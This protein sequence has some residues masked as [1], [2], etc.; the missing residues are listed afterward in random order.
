MNKNLLTFAETPRE[1]LEALA[2]LLDAGEPI[3]HQISE[4]CATLIREALGNDCRMA[5]NKRGRPSAEAV[6]RERADAVAMLHIIDG[7]KVNDAIAQVAAEYRR[8]F[9]TVQKDYKKW[10]R[11]A[12]WMARSLKE[13]KGGRW[14][15][16][17]KS[18]QENLRTFRDENGGYLDKATADEVAG[19][20]P[21]R[22]VVDLNERIV[23]APLR[24]DFKLLKDILASLRQG[25]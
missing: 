17:Y 11:S 23:N 16:A 24:R 19:R 25:N 12:R 8:K 15:R 9:G 1:K 5:I 18:L 14:R 22:L 7:V 4:S 20:L 6:S 13:I 3:P 10:G 2:K 21:A